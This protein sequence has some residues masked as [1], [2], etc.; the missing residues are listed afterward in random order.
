[1]ANTGKKVVLTLKERIIS[2][3]LFTGITKPNLS[4]DS[5]YIAPATNTTAC[6]ITA[7]L[8]CPTVVTQV[9]LDGISYEFSLLESVYTNP[10]LKSI[11]VHL[12][13]SGV[14]VAQQSFTLP[15]TNYFTNKFI[16]TAGTYDL[17]IEYKDIT[18]AVI[19][20][21]AISTLTVV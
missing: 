9:H 21:C 13:Q 2:T 20:T 16:V 19:A 7:D 3:G 18:P 17:V 10:T 5:D 1:M 4:S 11:T 12:K 8:T 14:S 6:P 15:Q